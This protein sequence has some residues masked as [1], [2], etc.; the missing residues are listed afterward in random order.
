[1]A[2]VFWKKERIFFF[3]FSVLWN[4]V[5]SVQDAQSHPILRVENSPS[6]LPQR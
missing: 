5:F 6:P 2:S 4:C 3:I 1:L